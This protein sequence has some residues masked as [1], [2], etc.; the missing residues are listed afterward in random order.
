VYEASHQ[1]KPKAAAP[2]AN[3]KPAKI[4]DVNTLEVESVSSEGSEGSTR[5]TL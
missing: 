3:D 4:E 5:C 1:D 2:E